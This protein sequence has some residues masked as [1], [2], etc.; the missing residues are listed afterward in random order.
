MLYFAT[1]TILKGSPDAVVFRPARPGTGGGG[2][3]VGFCCTDRSAAASYRDGASSIMSDFEE[4]E[5]QLS[6][7]RQGEE[8]HA[9]RGPLRE[10][11]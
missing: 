4:F 1:D 9:P 10:A 7:N 2:V 11:S 5:K 3:S 6:E 8:R